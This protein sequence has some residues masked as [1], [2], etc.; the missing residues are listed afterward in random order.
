MKPK[1]YLDNA[2]TTPM[3]DEV[4]FEMNK[5]YKDIFYNPSARYEDAYYVN[6]VLN[7]CRN[8][9]AKT[10]N[11]LPEEIYFTSGGSESDNWALRYVKSGG[12]IITSSIEHHAILNTCKYLESIGIDVTY[13]N[14][15]KNGLLDPVLVENSIRNNTSLISVMM[16]NNEIGTIE[17]INK[18][19]KIA[20]EHNI[21]FHTDAVQTYGHI[22]IDVRLSGIDMMSV[23]AH[24]FGGPKGVGFLY[25]K[26]GID[27]PTLIYGG[28]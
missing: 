23:S 1:V 11:C 22:D 5:Y 3:M 15:D 6:N 2:A 13:I 28:H 10:I 25:I 16:A 14:V 27:L 24:K 21:L 9:I 26:H 12:H 17:P 19:A 4:I 18:I 8:T 20:S 7:S